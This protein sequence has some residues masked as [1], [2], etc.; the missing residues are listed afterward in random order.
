MNKLINSWDLSDELVKAACQMVTFFDDLRGVK[1]ASSSAFSEEM[2][3][4]WIPDDD[5]FAVHLIAMGCGEDYGFNKNGDYW[6]RE[7]LIRCHQT[8]VKNGHFFREHRNRDP[9]LAIGSV[10]AGAWNE[11]MGRVEL[12]VWGDKR[13]AEPEYE[14]AKAGKMSSYSMS[15]RVPYD[16]CSCCDHKAKRSSLY[17]EDLKHHMTQWRPRFQKFAYAINDD[18]VFFDIS[19]VENPADRTAHYLQYILGKEDQQ[20]AKAASAGQTFIFSD[21]QAD[22]SGLALPDGFEKGCSTPERQEI[23]A[24]LASAEAYIESVIDRPERFSPGDPKF[25]FLKNAAVYGFD[26]TAVN[27][28]QLEV[29]RSVEPDILFHRLAKQAAVMPFLTFYAYVTQQPIKQ[30]SEDPA[31]LFASERLLSRVFRDALETPADPEMESAFSAASLTKAAG[32]VTTDPV[33]QV[34]EGVAAHLSI[35]KPVAKARI[36]RNCAEMPELGGLG[37][38]SAHAVSEDIQR[39]ARLYARAY[40]LYKVSFVETAVGLHGNSVIDDP[41]L[42]L[43]TYPYRV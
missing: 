18:G 21:V 1:S 28:A 39:K 14:R 12:V 40:A 7:M 23:L 34:L 33:D 8:F 10:K 2:M 31:Y 24:K 6:P 36:M 9:K 5:H 4:Q 20:L 13:K 3:K 22:A 29:L 27:D 37:V 35:D 11:K 25:D 42:M 26:P 15:C 41:S 32:A 38:K 17:C 30:A 16:R 43:I 19:D